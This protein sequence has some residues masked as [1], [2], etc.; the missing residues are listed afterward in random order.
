MIPLPDKKY[1]I[2][3]ADPPWGYQN[4]GTR[5]AASK[6]YGTMTVEELKKMDV[7]AAGGVLLAATAPSLCG[8]P[9]PMLREALE[10]IEAWGFTYK[11]VA[12]NWVKQNKTGAGLF[13]GLGNWTRSNSEICLLAVK[14][15][16]KRMSASVHSVI[17]SPVQQHSRKPAET[18]DRIVELMGDLPRIELFAREAA[19]G[20]DAW[21]NEAPTPGARKEETDGQNDPGDPAPEL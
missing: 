10:V 20:W 21:G 3:Y 17:L 6:H 7:G 12:F 11:T 4:R 13:W 18:R 9:F 5:A 19:P 1:S 15:K 8:R 2:I 14:G 16:P